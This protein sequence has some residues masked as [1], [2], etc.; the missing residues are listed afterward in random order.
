M[1][2]VGLMMLSRAGALLLLA[3]PLSKAGSEE[4]NPYRDVVKI[5]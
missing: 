4:N 2:R 3:R 1:Y 5:I